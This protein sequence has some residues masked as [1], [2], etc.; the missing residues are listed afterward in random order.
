MN[1]KGVTLTELMI[2]IAIMGILGMVVIYIFKYAWDSWQIGTVKMSLSQQGRVAMSLIEHDLK[3]AERCT[4]NNFMPFRGSSFEWPVILVPD[5]CPVG[6]GWTTAIPAPS[7]PANIERTEEGV[8][9]GYYALRIGP[10]SGAQLESDSFTL[11]GGE[12]YVL[13]CWSR[14]L[15]TE[16]GDSGEIGI[17]SE[18]GVALPYSPAPSGTSVAIDTTIGYWRRYLLTFT[19]PAGD[20]NYIIRLTGQVTDADEYIYFDDVSVS[21]AG[22]ADFVTDKVTG[23]MTVFPTAPGGFI[24]ETA[25]TL[26]FQRAEGAYFIVRLRLDTSDP[27]NFK[28]IR[29]KADW[30]GTNNVIGN[31]NSIG[32]GPLAENVN[33]FYIDN[34]NQDFFDIYLDLQTSKKGGVGAKSNSYRLKTRV[35]PSVP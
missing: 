18:D 6:W 32:A 21:F 1:K 13:S 20:R 29:E 35:Y 14:G 10:A 28:I 33:T 22:R 4:I 15:N 31:W 24:F 8:N 11:R 12:T 25:S 17:S 2:A 34:I 7:L 3:G 5:E 27:D 30:D 19:A 23:V 9:S 16:V 26:D